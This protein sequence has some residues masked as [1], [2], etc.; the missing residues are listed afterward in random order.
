VLVGAA[1]VFIV[2][3][4][5]D[6]GGSSAGTPRGL[7]GHGRAV[8]SGRPTTGLLKV[9]GAVGGGVIVV[10]AIPGRTITQEVLGV[11]LVAG[12]ANV[13]NGLDVR[14]GRAGTWFLIAGVALSAANPLGL[15]LYMVGAELGVIFFDL[16]EWAMLGDAGANLLGFVIG[17]GLYVSLRSTPALISATVVVVVLN[18]VAETVS[19]SRIIESVPPL[20]WFDRIGRLPASGTDL[21]AN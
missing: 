3:L 4:I 11:L 5:D 7:R 16:R 2:G 13:W 9:V 12:A 18:L 21:S 8:A 1:L 14:P 6:L 10:M 19:F 20:R 15:V 17:T